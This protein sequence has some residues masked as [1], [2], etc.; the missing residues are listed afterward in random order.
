MKEDAELCEP[1]NL[2]KMNAKEFILRHSEKF[3]EAVDN[4]YDIR[5]DEEEILE[6]ME[7]YRSAKYYYLKHGEIIQEGDECEVSN[8]IHDPAKWVPAGRTVGTAAPD[9]SYPAHRKYRRLI[10]RLNL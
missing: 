5:M 2:K 8:S 4:G 10:N 7:R 6:W 3:R 9:P 1:F